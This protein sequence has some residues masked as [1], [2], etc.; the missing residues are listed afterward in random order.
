MKIY[1]NW[2][3]MCVTEHPRSSQS[4]HYPRL[5]INQHAHGIGVQIQKSINV[6]EKKQILNKVQCFT[7]MVTL[8]IL[9]FSFLTHFSL[10]PS[11]SAF[12]QTFVCPVPISPIWKPPPPSYD[13]AS[14]SC[15]RASN[16]SPMGVLFSPML[17]SLFSIL[18]FRLR[19]LSDACTRT[20]TVRQR[21]RK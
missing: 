11:G 18:F 14:C 16:R 3:W 15:P 1:D 4:V 12:L 9:N 5:A 6:G 10:F 19:S 20:T 17:S 7:V 13:P 8:R 2:D 21:K